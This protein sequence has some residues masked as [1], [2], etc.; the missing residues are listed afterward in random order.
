MGLLLWSWWIFTTVNTQVNV[1]KQSQNCVKFLNLLAVSRTENEFV[2]IKILVLLMVFVIRV[3]QFT[4]IM[5]LWI[6]FHTITKARTKLLAYS[7]SE[8]FMK[9]RAFQ[10]FTINFHTQ[11]S[12]AAPRLPLRHIARRS[13]HM[14]QGL[15]LFLFPPWKKK[16]TLSQRY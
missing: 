11:A 14:Q 9:H 10:H 8:T 6:S 15:E 3:R 7:E 4:K 5:V 16:K 2:S 13:S 1:V 12:S